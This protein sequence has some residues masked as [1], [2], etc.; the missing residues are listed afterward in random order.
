[1]LKYASIHTY[2]YYIHP[3]SIKLLTRSYPY[4]LQPPIEMPRHENSMNH[5]Q[6]KDNMIATNE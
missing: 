4:K 6:L 1:M 2:N 5:M 3:M